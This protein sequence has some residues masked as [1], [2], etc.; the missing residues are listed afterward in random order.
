MHIFEINC[1]YII[2]YI[3]AQ[4]IPIHTALRI[5]IYMYIVNSIHT[6]PCD[7]HTMHINIYSLNMHML[8]ITRMN[9][10]DMY[11]F[12]VNNMH[13][14]DMYLNTYIRRVSIKNKYQSIVL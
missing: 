10:M 9:D 1:K 8:C 2:L 14:N 7:T 4:Y 13:I 12:Y 6:K 5:I 3:N 11:S